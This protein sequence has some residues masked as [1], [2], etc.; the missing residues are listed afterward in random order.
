M[1]IQQPYNGRVKVGDRL[2]IDRFCSDLPIPQ[3]RVFDGKTGVV[4]EVEKGEDPKVDEKGMMT[5]CGTS[6]WY[7]L[8]LDE[9][10]TLNGTVTKKVPVLP[11]DA[12]LLPEVTHANP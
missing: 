1:P 8:L 6:D 3:L 11:C 7:Q 4:I 5:S 9:P 10:V 12:T 2:R